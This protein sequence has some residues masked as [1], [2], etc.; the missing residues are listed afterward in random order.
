[1]SPATFQLLS[2]NRKLA[3]QFQRHF[4]GGWRRNIPLGPFVASTY[5]S[6]SATCP[7]TCTFKNNGCYEQE[8]ASK[9]HS[10]ARDDAAEGWTAFEVTQAEAA[11]IDLMWKHGVPQDGARG[12][13]DLRLH[14]GGDV[15]C[16]NGARLL[17]EAA[18]RYRARGGGNVWVY[19]HRWREIPVEAWGPAISVLASCDELSEVPEAWRSGYAVAVAVPEFPDGARAFKLGR[20]TA[21]PCPVEAGA[22]TTCATCRLCMD[23]LRLR[24]SNLVIAFQ[25]H[26]NGVARRHLPILQP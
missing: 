17:A 8:G 21:I 25:E 15:S 23:D 1:M 3:P 2:A 20:R 16:S 5:V 19:T 7:D 24:G 22:K 6:I 18:Q 14:V 10:R 13:R 12:G 26:G 4:P 9:K 11:K